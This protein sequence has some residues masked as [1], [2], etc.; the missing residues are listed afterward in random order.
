MRKFWLSSPVVMTTVSLLRPSDFSEEEQEGCSTGPLLCLLGF[1][2]GGALARKRG[3]FNTRSC[4]DIVLVQISVKKTQKLFVCQ[5]QRSKEAQFISFLIR[6]ESSWLRHGSTNSSLLFHWTMRRVKEGFSL[7]T[8][9]WH[10]P[11]HVSFRVPHTTIPF[12]KNFIQKSH[13][14]KQQQQIQISYKLSDTLL[15]QILFLIS[16]SFPIMVDCRV[17]LQPLF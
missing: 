8:H 17:R 12:K 16:F 7:H 15:V 6:N 3:S 9:S 14:N 2:G 10:P 5:R 13:H 1:C 4:R 11:I